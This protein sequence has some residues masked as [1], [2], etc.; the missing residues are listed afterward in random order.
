MAEATHV[1]PR[2]WPRSATWRRRGFRRGLTFYL[3]ISPWLLGFVLLGALPLAGAFLMSLTNYDGLNL[4]YVRFVGI[5]T[6][7]APSAIPRR[8][9]R[10]DA[11]F[12]S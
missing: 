3:L 6:T 1:L 2:A 11:R 10:W 8:S 12:C 4:D 9:T 7:S 5:K